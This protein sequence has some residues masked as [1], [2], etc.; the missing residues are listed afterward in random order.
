MRHAPAGPEGKLQTRFQ[1]EECDRA[2]LEFIA[3]DSIARQAEAVAV[4]P[5][6]FLEIV[7]PKR[8]ESDSGLHTA[9]SCCTAR[10]ASRMEFRWSDAPARSVLANAIRPCGRLRRTSRGAGWPLRPKKKP[11]C[12]LT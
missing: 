11:G 1:L 12:G 2:V 9:R 4:E 8:D 10:S 3:H 7:H 5:Q 6:R